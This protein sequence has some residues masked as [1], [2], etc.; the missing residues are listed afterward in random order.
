MAVPIYY[1]D[2]DADRLLCCRAQYHLRKQSFLKS[3]T[4]ASYLLRPSTCVAFRSFLNCPLRQ[5]QH[6]VSIL[7]PSAQINTTRHKPIGAVLKLWHRQIVD[8]KLIN[9]PQHF[10]R[11]M[12][13]IGKPKPLYNVESKS[14]LI[15]RCG[16]KGIY[17]KQKENG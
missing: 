9:N 4:F 6:L 5:N 2:D 14:L 3:L 17:L 8:F 15:L 10:P 16:V 12:E 13:K 7:L 11:Q 1:L